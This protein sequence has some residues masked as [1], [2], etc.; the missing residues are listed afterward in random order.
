MWSSVGF[1]CA[2][3]HGCIEL[4]GWL[5]VGLNWRAGMAGPLS[6]CGPSASRRLDWATVGAALQEDMTQM[7][8]FLSS[9]YFCHI[10]WCLMGQ[11]NS[12]S[13]VQSQCKET[14][15]WCEHWEV[16]TGKINLTIYDC[17]LS[18]LSHMQIHSYLLRPSESHLIMTSWEKLLNSWFES[19][20][21]VDK[22]LWVSFL[23]IWRPANYK[24][25]LPDC[26]TQYT[27]VRQ[28]TELR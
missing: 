2:Y 5:E 3:S 20:L 16:F 24:E 12:C 21:D 27:M 15:H 10:F 14:P 4:E 23:L 22:A 25:M 9:L 28:R 19:G 18:V 26:F 1:T 11:R 17:L 8:K 13:Q 7:Y 6:L